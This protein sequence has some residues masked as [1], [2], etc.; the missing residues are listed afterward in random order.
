MEAQLEHRMMLSSEGHERR[1]VYHCLKRLLDIVVSL[2]ALIVFFPLMVLSVFD[3]SDFT[4][5]HLSPGAHRSVAMGRG[6]ERWIPTIHYVQVPDHARDT[7][8]GSTGVRNG[9]YHSRYK[10]HVGIKA[11]RLRSKDRE[12]PAI[13][14]HGSSCGRQPRQLPQLWTFSRDM[15]HIGP[16]RHLHTIEDTTVACGDS[17]QAWA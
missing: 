16:R 15:K 3:R 12:R 2:I 13:H 1:R 11:T 8:S 4:R 14:S 9:F 7:D 5:R 10:F 17:Q 6:L